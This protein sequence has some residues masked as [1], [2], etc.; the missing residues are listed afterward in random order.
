[1]GAA[2]SVSKADV[3]TMDTD[4][5]IAAL[6]SIGPVYEKYESALVDNGVTGDMIAALSPQ[7]LDEVS[8]AQYFTIHRNCEGLQCCYEVNRLPPCLLRFLWTWVSV[9][10]TERSSNVAW[11]T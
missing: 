3:S 1:M 2:A 5:V 4:G 11:R 10:Y 7:E 6:K 9:R 8:I